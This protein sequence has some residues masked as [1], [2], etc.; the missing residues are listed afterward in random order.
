MAKILLVNPNS[1]SSG[2]NWTVLP[3]LGLLYVGTTLSLSN[4]TVKVLDVDIADL[5][6][7]AVLSKTLEFE[8]NVIG[9]SLNCGQLGGGYQLIRAMKES[10]PNVPI[11]V[12]GP[13]PSAMKADIFVE[14]PQV[15]VVVVGE[16]EQ[17]MLE[18]VEAMAAGAKLES[19][20]GIVY[21]EDGSAVS[22]PSRPYIQN[23][24]ELPQP[25][26]DL[27]DGLAVYPGAYPI[28]A[29]PQIHVM[30]GRGCPF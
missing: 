16:G 23:L 20:K 28:G 15:D 29:H 9:L 6:I 12:G 5:S 7:D 24:D 8:P 27:L 19:V 10:L 18:L 26:Y 30:A 2:A 4:H 13:H 22:N 21:K 17:T 1:R 3:P 25:N 14:C 11:V